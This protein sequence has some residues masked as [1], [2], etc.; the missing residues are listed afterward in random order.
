MRYINLL[1]LFICFTSCD[2]DYKRPVI[3]SE[4]SVQSIFT[5]STLSVRAIDCNDEYLFYGSADHFGKRAYGK[6]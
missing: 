1:V 5:D 3:I 6:N 2:E 4:V